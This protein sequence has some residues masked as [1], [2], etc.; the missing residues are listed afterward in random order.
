MTFGAEVRRRRKAKKLTLEKLAGKSGLSPNY[1]G[2]VERG[3]RDPSLS[4][5]FALAK[6]L[7]V[8]AGELLGGVEG[9]SPA[10]IEAGKLF[11]AVPVED[12]PAMLTLLSSLGKR[13]R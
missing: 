7:G 4:T 8:S 12:R 1:L 3:D 10:G 11:E 13:K 9:L 5:V 2:G 6:G